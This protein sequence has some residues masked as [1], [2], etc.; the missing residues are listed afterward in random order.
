MAPRRGWAAVAVL[1][2]GA[3]IGCEG[4]GTPLQAA[5]VCTETLLSVA[6]R[7]FACTG[8]AELANRRFATFRRTLTCQLSG[9]GVQ[10]PVDQQLACATDLNQLGCAQVTMFGDDAAMWLA[11]SPYCVLVF[12]TAGGGP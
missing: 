7:T 5:D 12:P 3:A 11:A 1:L 10:G 4:G 9:G 8:N 2:L 6:N